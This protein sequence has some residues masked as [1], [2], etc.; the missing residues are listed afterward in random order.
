M[1]APSQSHVNTAG[2]IPDWDVSAPRM[3]APSQSHV[4]TAGN[5]LDWDVSAP[6]MV[7]PSQPHVNNFIGQP[8]LPSVHQVQGAWNGSGN[9]SLSSQSLGTGGNSDQG[10]FS[11]LSQCNQLRSGSPYESI[12]HTDQFLSPRTY[13]VVDAGTH[14]INAVVPPS[15]HPL[16]YFSG[17]DAPGALLPDDITWMNL[18]PQNPALN[19]QMGKSYLRSW[20]R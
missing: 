16:D 18:P 15:S 2:N 6:R 11:V 10:L 3:I 7:A 14:R 17:R 12:R 19:D 1:V 4:N 20:N 13:G 8:W 9:G 5:I